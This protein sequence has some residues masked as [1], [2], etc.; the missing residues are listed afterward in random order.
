MVNVVVTDFTNFLLEA[1]LSTANYDATLIA[2]D[3][4]DPVNSLDV[5]FG[6]SKYTAGGAGKRQELPWQPPPAV[7]AG[8]SMMEER[9]QIKYDNDGNTL[10]ISG[11]L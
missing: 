8:Q 9:R 5:H 4:Q 3:A 11:N 1:S 7:I 10:Y 2:W 6:N